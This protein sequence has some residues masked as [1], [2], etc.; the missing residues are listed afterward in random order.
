[1]RQFMLGLILVIAQAALSGLF[2]YWAASRTSRWARIAGG[3]LAVVVGWTSI[4]AVTNRIAG[5]QSAP[6]DTNLTI[7]IALLVGWVAG[8]NRRVRGTTRGPIFDQKVRQAGLVIMVVS[9]VVG[10]AW[11]LMTFAMELSIVN[12]AAGFWGFVVACVIAPVTFALAPLYAGVAHQDWL[13][14]VF[15]YGGMVSLYLGIAFGSLVS[16]E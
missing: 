7:L 4:V 6:L 1:M 11:G 3:V 16:Q 5:Y 9:Y 12:E 14:A 8:R 15:A 2:A 13:P 10:V